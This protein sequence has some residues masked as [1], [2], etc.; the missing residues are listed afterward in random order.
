MQVAEGG[1]QLVSEW[2]AHS[3]EAWCTAF[4]KA[5]VSCA[6][7]RIPRRAAIWVCPTNVDSQL[8]P[9][10]TKCCFNFKPQTCAQCQ[11]SHSFPYP[12]LLRHLVAPSTP[13]PVPHLNP[14]AH[15]LQPHLL[16]SGA[17]DCYFKGHDLRADFSG[18]PGLVFSDR[19]SHAAGVC[20]VSPHPHPQ[21]S[22][23]ARAV[24]TAK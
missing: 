12:R 3:L 13:T 21:V 1:L 8:K 20:T 14:H 16:F 4:H 5:E 23:R 10:G 6:A 11:P 22:T 2:E 17:D 24:D 15:A 9:I 7:L 18:P 19:R